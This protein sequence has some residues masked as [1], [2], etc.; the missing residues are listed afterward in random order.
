MNSNYRKIG[1][2]VKLVDERNKD[3]SISNV[4]GMNVSKSFMPSVANVSESDLRNY[5]VIRKGQFAYSAM[6]VGRDETIRVALFNNDFPAIV[7]PAYHV[8]EI[9]DPD[10]YAEYL[11]MIFHQPEFNRY[12]WFISDGS[13]RASLEW[14]RFIDIEVPVPSPASQ[15][16][17]VKFFRGF[18]ELSQSYQTSASKLEKICNGFVDKIMKESRGEPLGSLIELVDERNSDLM[19]D[20][21]LGVNIKKMFMPTVANT[22]E[23]DLKR[24]KVIRKNI[25]ACNIMHVGRDEVFPVSLSTSE[26]PFLVSPAYVTF[27]A[28]PNID[29]DYLMMLFSRP[30]F[31][32]L[33]W[34]ISDSSI[35]GGLDWDRFL[36]LR[37]PLPKF[38][39]QKNAGLLFKSLQ[40][41]R[42][43]AVSFSQ[44]SK[45]IAPILISSIKNRESIS[46]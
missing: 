1:S 27:R 26:S 31:D 42:N 7:S 28:R 36:E 5:K 29:S 35:R 3:N 33:T 41:S 23:L 45:G 37:L 21:I 10:I 25:F 43:L 16:R 32:R 19:F 13:V 38:E 17:I 9:S 18:T 6:Q 4:L 46:I 15:E 2:I 39:I 34:F 40:S 44:M 12:G 22:S 11:M 30:E 20:Q 14:E 8:F 24:Y